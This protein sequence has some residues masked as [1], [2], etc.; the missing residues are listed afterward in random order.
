MILRLF[1]RPFPDD[2]DRDEVLLLRAAVC[3]ETYSSKKELGSERPLV[4]IK[5]GLE[6][7]LVVLP[8][9]AFLLDSITSCMISKTFLQACSS[10]TC[11]HLPCCVS[12]RTK[13]PAGLV[14]LILR[15]TRATISVFSLRRK[16]EGFASLCVV[17]AAFSVVV[18]VVVVVMSK[19]PLIFSSW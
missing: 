4:D 15:T 9:L 18:V 17:V 1:R 2:A 16:A 10:E 14:L 6:E 3:L 13:P 5:L 11:A 7:L 12:I 19:A 8:V